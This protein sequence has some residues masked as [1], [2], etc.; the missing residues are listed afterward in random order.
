MLLADRLLDTGFPP[1]RRF[2]VLVAQIPPSVNVAIYASL[3]ACLAI[4]L[5]WVK[6]VV[7]TLTLP[8]ED[9]NPTILSGLS[10]LSRPT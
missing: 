4:I 5:G 1:F 3:F 6:R 9:I 8:S 7:G 10:V 2:L